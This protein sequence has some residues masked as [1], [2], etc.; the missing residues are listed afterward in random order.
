MRAIVRLLALSALLV[1]VAS[2]GALA[3]S[4]GGYSLSWW[5]VDSGGGASAGGGYS[6]SGT[7]GQAD[8]GAQA[9]GGYN[10]RG[11]F[12]AGMAPPPR[13]AE[14]PKIY[15]PQISGRVAAGPDLVV[16]AIGTAGGRLEIVIANLGDTA[17][18]APFWVDLAIE[19]RRAPDAPNDT[20]E[21]VG[22][23]G[24]AWG[25]TAAL[26]PGAS[27]T[28][29]PGDTFYRPEK[30]LPG[31]SLAQGDRLYAHVDS[32][33]VGSADGA[34][35]ESHE[36]RGEPYNNVLAASAEGAVALPGATLSVAPATG[37]PDR[38]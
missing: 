12:W 20:W 15:L 31:G 1:A 26:P 24:M 6:L 7:A 4:G 22:A 8:A 34:V 5:T 28:L 33:S 35:R 16:Q 13:P 9:G 38:P 19:P 2:G 17:V 37:L 14:A 25:V 10:L 18:A 29:R 27:L 23:R 21:M 32:A 3:S 30:S 11:G 36:R